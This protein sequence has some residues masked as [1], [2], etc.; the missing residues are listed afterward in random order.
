MSLG[1]WV[2][3][4]AAAVAVVGL[5]FR[6]GR[7]M[8][9]GPLKTEKASAD[10]ARADAER[11][12]ADDRE[13]FIE[14]DAKYKSLQQDMLNLRLNKSNVFL[15]YEIDTLLWQA[16]EALGVVESSIL[17]PGPP[18]ESSTFVFLAVNG[19]AAPRLRLTKLPIDSGIVGRVF[20]TGT[21]H[22]T[23]NPYA[24]PNFSSAVDQ[25]GNHRTQTILTVPLV[26][27]GETVGVAQFLNKPGGFGAADEA[28]ATEFAGLLAGKVVAFARE[29]E[30]F[31]LLLGLAGVVEEEQATI[32]FC[33]LTAFSPFL[34]QMN[35]AGAVD[36]LNE[37][38]IQQCEVAMGHGGTVE[39]YLGDGAMLRFASP[40]GPEG[41]EVADVIDAALE[42]QDGF[43]HLKE[44]WLNA[45]LPV[46]GL[47]S[48]IGVSRGAVH[49]VKL[50]HPQFQELTVIGDPVNEASALCDAP[51]ATPTSSWSP[52]D[53]PRGWRDGST[54][55]RPRPA[56]RA[57]R[58]S[59]FAGGADTGSFPS[60]W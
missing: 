46:E 16:A 17:L 7:N 29:P 48:R 59:K 27:G 14:V 21:L 33:D 22:N 9:E 49:E 18:P 6:Y 34:R 45:S 5:V 58:P 13:R 2:G 37:Y 47:F 24:D 44:S 32:A 1:L 51:G 43:R 42:M 36:C 10:A 35:A 55:S 28:R 60:N 25:K 4:V 23:S 41:D 54:W 19:P 11:R 52:A 12:S 57:P 15:K 3:I 31:E 53:W 50:G 30:N 39:K 40:R 26:V 38:L 56:P 8:V 20:A